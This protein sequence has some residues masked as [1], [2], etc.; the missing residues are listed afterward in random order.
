MPDPSTP[1]D[2]FFRAYV[3]CALWSSNDDD[4]EPLDDTY[5]DD[6]IDPD[7]L[8]RMKEDA[9]S[10]Y[11]AHHHLWRNGESPSPSEYTIDELAGHDFWL[12]RNGHGT[13]FWDRDPSVYPHGNRHRLTIYAD[14]YGPCDCYVTD[15][16]KIAL[17]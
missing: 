12:T 13:G 9:L 7:S 2:D 3:A 14:T 1:F 5:T 17:I 6:D 10:F 15:D 4:G 11:T 16:N 8:A